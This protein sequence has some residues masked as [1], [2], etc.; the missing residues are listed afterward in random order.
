M[1]PKSLNIVPVVLLPVILFLSA[2]N[3][4]SGGSAG[5]NGAINGGSSTG[6]TTELEGTWIFCV[7]L[8]AGDSDSTTLNFI[9]NRFT[10][11]VVRHSDA[12]CVT[13]VNTTASY[14]GSFDIGNS[15]T[16]KTGLD[17]KKINMFY[18]EGFAAGQQPTLY[19]IFWIQGT[20]LYKGLAT[21]DNN[22]L[23]SSARPDEINF[24]APYY[25]Q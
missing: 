4:D 9:G 23:S 19:D 13:R 16:L 10:E 20:T 15:V 25:M 8:E 24:S 14:S 7:E 3:G 17:V 18:A 22:L 6:A 11:E 1:L 21:A 12:D 5:D 2:C